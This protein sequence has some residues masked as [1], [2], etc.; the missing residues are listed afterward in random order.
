MVRSYLRHEPVLAYSLVTSPSNSAHVHLDPRDSRT[1]YVPALEDVLVWDTKLGTQLAAWH[2][3]GL[4]SA[5]TAIARAPS[6]PP[7]APPSPIFAVGYA[8]GSIR[9]WDASSGTA[10]VTF[11]GHKSAV[12]TLAFDSQGLILASGSQ[13]TDLILW[14]V[15]AEAGLFRLRGHRDAV[16]QVA[17]VP[18][19]PLT[20]TETAAA[21]A[22]DTVPG[23][24]TGRN[25]IGATRYLLSTA[26]DGFLKLW[27]LSLQHCV[28]TVIPGKGE[29]W[30]LATA[31]V[32][33]LG[34]KPQD[35]EGDEAADSDVVP[36]S[37]V[38]MTGGTEGQTQVYELN[39]AALRTGLQQSKGDEANGGGSNKFVDHIG[40]VPLAAKNRVTQIAFSPLPRSS[41]RTGEEEL[42]PND[43]QEAPYLAISSSDRS[44]QVF[45]LR[46]PEEVRHRL[47]R[48]KR[49][50]KEKKKEK[51][52]K[53]RRKSSAMDDD[54][55]EEDDEVEEEQG[56]VS[57]IDRLVQHAIVRP[58]S[59][60]HLKSFS[61]ALASSSGTSAGAKVSGSAARPGLHV[62]LGLNSNALETWT[63]P[64]AGQGSSANT[65]GAEQAA[66]APNGKDAISDEPLLS[67]SVDLPGHRAEVRAMALSPDDTLLASADSAGILK[68]WNVRTGRCIRTFPGCGYALS[69][70]WLPGARHLVLG[71]K[72]G[73]IKTFD[74]P[75]ALAVQ[76]VPGAGE[77][78]K[79]SG[80]R[81]NTG[82]LFRSPNPAHAG[83]VWSLALHP[84]GLSCVSAS[85][86]KT[87]KF[88]EFEMH[89]VAEI[90]QQAGQEAVD[91]NQSQQQQLVMVHVRTLKMTDDI[92]FAKFS[93]NGRLLALALLDATV[94]VFF[95]DSLKFFLSLYG[96][97]LP[98]LALDI[99]SD[100]KL[101]IT[102]SADKNV[103]IWGLDF[104]DCH[105]SL[106]AHEDSIMA[107]GF[108]QGEQGGGLMGGREGASHHF[109]TAGKDGLLKHWDG[110]RFELIQTLEGHH[111]EIWAL[112]VDS[113]GTLCVTAGADRSIRTWEKTDEPLFLEEERERELEQMYE[114]AG[115]AREADE[116]KAIGS[117]AP[118]ADAD[119]GDS[120][121]GPEAIGVQK[122]T[123][124]TLMA[125][126]RLMEALDIGDEDRRNEHLAA[127]GGF[128]LAGR[129]PR[130][131]L[132][133]ASFGLGIGGVGTSSGGIESG[134]D[135]GGEPSG[136]GYVLKE[137][138]KILPAQLE[139]ALLVLPF[140]KVI[141]LMQYL[142]LW[143][144][145]DW[146]I[147]L[148]SRILF[149]LL[150][151]HHAQIVSNKVMRT[152]LINLRIHLQ[153][154]LARQRD[155]MGFNLA[156]L[157]HARGV[158]VS[159]RTAE[160]YERGPAGLDLD[161]EAVR[162]KIEAG[163]RKR[164]VAIV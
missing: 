148:T 64:G 117:L 34:N 25:M 13:D 126:E 2:E 132:L 3:T 61:L 129:P 35:D 91:S 105:R 63:V 102:V 116:G 163:T 159:E 18:N 52:N 68:I 149:F 155:T 74:V 22:G 138:E 123:K 53:K 164:K 67:A 50:A 137:V 80:K 156:A 103:K 99:S 90:R 47:A 26:K 134:A 28:E 112:A 140:D 144:K 84:N 36:M 33:S 87:V 152:T 133:L 58:S 85:A 75:A 145:K 14:D 131:Q 120:A 95:S 41:R 119:A 94:K 39:T 62:L 31:L 115:G 136:E 92:L 100:S 27:D 37:I 71:C 127:T 4:R 101:A 106:Y 130:N 49:R 7:S 6:S 57:F 8:D 29:L 98:V 109:W 12:T 128:G 60:G 82:E 77:R 86:D 78:E 73:S 54:K 142:D 72:D 17:F 21:V 97:K 66:S 1:A 107:C 118:G 135:A 19:L 150:R 151:T 139:D 23:P 5:V 122:S 43:I 44:V 88:W 141:S 153:T 51:A 160:M 162:Q 30:S 146:N 16:T 10:T 40:S 48:Q 79:E 56:D 46:T 38:V 89:S 81:E 65:N 15:V 59:G 154:A 124:E 108:E 24:S 157:R 104:G 114:R 32:R 111:G 45:R 93:P 76:V 158:W 9:L 20:S 42:A 69:L 70:I 161:E 83:P 147:S 96:H 55:E 110:D 113:K 143:A 11:N 125:G 121:N